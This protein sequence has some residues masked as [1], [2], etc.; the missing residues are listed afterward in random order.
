MPVTEL[1]EGLYT[2]VH[3]RVQT[4]LFYIFK[5]HAESLNLHKKRAYA[6]VA[7]RKM[8]FL[9]YLHFFMRHA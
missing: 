7:G 1:Y 9:K 3:K 5:L 2:S 6:L 4:F 8:Y